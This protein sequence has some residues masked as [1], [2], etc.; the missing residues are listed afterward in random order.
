MHSREYI[1]EMSGT[2][3]SDGL[4]SGTSLKALGGLAFGLALLGAA[5]S[6]LAGDLITAGAL[7]LY[8]PVGWLLFSI[9]EHPDRL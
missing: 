7:L 6:A 9:G 5:G 1:Q 3:R 8:L 4:L 2:V